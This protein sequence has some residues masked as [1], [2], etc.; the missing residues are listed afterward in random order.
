LLREMLYV[1]DTGNHAIRR[2]NL[3][4]GDIDT[5]CGSGR[6]GVT[7]EGPVQDPRSVSLDTPRAVAVTADQ[8]HIA[9]AGD[10]RIW[11]FELGILK[12]RIGHAAAE[13][14]FDAGRP[15]TSDDDRVVVPASRLLENVS[16]DI[17]LVSDPQ[18]HPAR[19]KP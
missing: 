17:L 4:S 14:A 7:K 11:S 13:E 8:L 2:I 19:V 6:R 1:A 3:R 16:G 15:M 5:L 9:L 18:R 12:Q 10:N